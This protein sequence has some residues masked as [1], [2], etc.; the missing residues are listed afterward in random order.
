MAFL[1]SICVL[2]GPSSRDD[3]FAHP[4]QSINDYSL[5]ASRLLSDIF[6]WRQR[7]HV[8]RCAGRGDWH[9]IV[10]RCVLPVAGDAERGDG[11]RGARDGHGAGVRRVGGGDWRSVVRVHPAHHRRQEGRQRHV[12]DLNRNLRFAPPN[13]LCDAMIC[14]MNQA[15]LHSVVFGIQLPYLCACMPLL[16]HLLLKWCEG[17][18]VT[19]FS[20]GIRWHA[21]LWPYLHVVHVL[22]KLVW[23]NCYWSVVCCDLNSLQI[24]VIFFVQYFVYLALTC[25]E[26]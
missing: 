23:T 16:I 3:R 19:R 8:S 9:G 14:D 18:S 12:S 4:L 1:C 11:V 15:L 5:T 7:R 25:C 21:N 10:G 17:F 24:H 13:S 6:L 22:G 20:I 2:V 26:F